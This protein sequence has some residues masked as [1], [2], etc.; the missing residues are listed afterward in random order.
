MHL[1]T[2]ILWVD[3]IKWSCTPLFSFRLPFV[4]SLPKLLLLK[5]LGGLLQLFILGDCN[6]KSFLI[7]R[8]FHSLIVFRIQVVKDTV[9]V[10]NH[11]RI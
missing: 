4:D 3:N 7:F 5:V 1:S 11:I 2:H 10:S 6:L 9:Q 8:V